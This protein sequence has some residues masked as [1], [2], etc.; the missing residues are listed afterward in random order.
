MSFAP[1]VWQ[2]SSYGPRITFGGPAITV[3]IL[4]SASFSTF[5]VFVALIVFAALVVFVPSSRFIVVFL[6]RTIERGTPGGIPDKSRTSS[7]QSGNVTKSGGILSV[8]AW[9]QQ[10]GLNRIA[11]VDTEKSEGKAHTCANAR[12]W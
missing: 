5:A 4:S 8:N 11:R 1:Q 3:A 9:L 6:L 7:R 10:L 2:P 12:G